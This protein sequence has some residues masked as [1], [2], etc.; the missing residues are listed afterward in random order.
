M[1][2]HIGNGLLYQPQTSATTLTLYDQ[3]SPDY[4]WQK[5]GI[6]SQIPFTNDWFLSDIYQSISPDLLHQIMKGMFKHIMDWV[7][8]ILA[9][10]PGWTKIAITREIDIRFKQIPLWPGLKKFPNGISTVQQW[11]GS[12][13]RQIMRIYL[14]VLQGL[15]S[16]NVMKPVR[17]FIDF[18]YMAES[19][20]HSDE[21]VR[22]MEGFLNQFLSQ[23]SALP[24]GEDKWGY[25]KL[26]M[27]NHYGLC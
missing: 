26:H 6:S 15:V 13:I 5:Y 27:L 25:I 9:N 19:K 14:G 24:P 21:T 11:Q 4:L 3:Y 16:P 23:Q 2:M 12:E 20:S 18:T 22:Y 17:S 1:K 10:K 8:E 7:D